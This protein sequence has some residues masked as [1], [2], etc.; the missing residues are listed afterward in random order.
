MFRHFLIACLPVGAIGKAVPSLAE[1][2][3]QA[4]G[5]ALIEKDLVGSGL[6][7]RNGRPARLAIKHLG[8]GHSS[9]LVGSAA[10][11]IGR[12]KTNC[13]SATHTEAPPSRRNSGARNGTIGSAP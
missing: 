8:D 1:V 10:R 9:L 3:A 11:A 6:E 5:T 13:G 4:A 2:H 12:H 7:I